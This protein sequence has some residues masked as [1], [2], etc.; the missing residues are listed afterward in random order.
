M[1]SWWSGKTIKWKKAFF[2]SFSP[3]I[4][5]RKLYCFNWSF[6]FKRGK[7]LFNW[8]GNFVSY[9]QQKHV[10]TWNNFEPGDDVTHHSSQDRASY[11]KWSVFWPILDRRSCFCETENVKYVHHIV[12]SA[13]PNGD[14]PEVLLYTNHTYRLTFR[15]YVGRLGRAFFFSLSRGKP[16]RLYLFS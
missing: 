1:G 15:W 5:P 2:I 12:W 9:K 16:N 4:M 13:S 6:K 11:S 14:I 8:S 10:H 3:A 7:T